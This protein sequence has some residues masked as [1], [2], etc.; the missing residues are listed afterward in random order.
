[1]ARI[2]TYR[3]DTNVT[4]SDKWIGTDGNDNNNTKN[5]SPNSIADFF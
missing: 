1:M 5:F 4:A 3:S 2:R